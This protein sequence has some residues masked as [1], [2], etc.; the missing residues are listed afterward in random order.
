M[1]RVVFMAVSENRRDRAGNVL[2]QKGRL[3]RGYFPATSDTFKKKISYIQN[4]NRLSVYEHHTQSKG[5]DTNPA[6][7]THGSS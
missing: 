5:S 6:C 3:H 2:N 1:P 4:I 7:P